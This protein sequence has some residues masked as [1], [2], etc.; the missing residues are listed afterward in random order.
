MLDRALTTTADGA[1]VG[2]VGL[3]SKESGFTIEIVFDP[4]GHVRLPINE[5]I[6]RILAIQPLADRP[7]MLVTY[8]TGQST[9]ARA[10]GVDVKK[11]TRPDDVHSGAADGD[12]RADAG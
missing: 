8:D 6:D 3:A 7:V 12:C 1:M 10:T 11:L 2:M 5:I 9:R 4:P